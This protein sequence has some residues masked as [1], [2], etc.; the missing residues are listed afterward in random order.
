MARRFDTYRRTGTTV[1]R[2]QALLYDIGQTFSDHALVYITG[3]GNVSECGANPATVAGVALNAIGTQPGF[4]VA[5]S[6]LTVVYTGREGRVSVA[7]ADSEQEFNARGVNGA[8]DP[9][10]P[11][12]A[13]IGQQ[14]GVLK[15]A[16]GDWVINIADQVNKVVQIT[17]IQL[18]ANKGGDNNSFFV[19]KFIPGVRQIP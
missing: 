13:H 2:I 9:V 14:Y 3:T 17:D 18:D 10:T 7:I 5:N 4:D 8:T 15:T 6:T 1:P 11:L 16:G 19:C 12:Q